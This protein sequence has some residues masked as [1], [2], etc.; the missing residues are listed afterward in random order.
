MVLRDGDI[1]EDVGREGITVKLPFL[2]E[3]PFETYFLVTL[4]FHVPDI[5]IPE[6]F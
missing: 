3:G 6:V 4:L 5:H 2:E 1:D